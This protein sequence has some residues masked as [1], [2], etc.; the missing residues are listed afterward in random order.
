MIYVIAYDVSDDRIRS[1]VASILE[2]HGRRV[3]A[4]VFECR[5]D[6]DTAQQLAVR[7]ADTLGT[8]DNG[9]VRL[10]RVCATCLSN[11]SAVG[12]DASNVDNAPCIIV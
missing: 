10:Y 9:G 1:T 6:A 8:P 2:G 4:S 12:A 11:S 5:I 3:Q 7:L